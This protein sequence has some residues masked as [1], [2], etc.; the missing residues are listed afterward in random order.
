M[1]SGIMTSRT[2]FSFGDAFAL[3]ALNAAAEC[4]VGALADL[5]GLV[6]GGQREPGPAFLG[7]VPGGFGGNY[8]A[9][10]AAARAAGADGRLLIRRLHGCRARCERAGQ[11]G[12][13]FLVAAEALLG[14]Q[15]GPLLGLVVVPAALV[16]LALAGLGGLAVPALD[17]VPGLANAR[18]FLG[19]LALFGFPQPG[20]GQRVRAGALLRGGE[21]A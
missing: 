16:L 13:G 11:P 10:G 5:L 18:V 12:L 4:G 3:A 2:S 7:R 6:D 8:R 9:G 21:H 1:T 20:V 17:G 19:D 14:F 15:L